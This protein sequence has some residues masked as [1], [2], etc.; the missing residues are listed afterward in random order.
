MSRST[1]DKELLKHRDKLIVEKY[2]KLYDIKRK[3]FDDVMY[4]LKWEYFFISEDTIK[5]ILRGANIDLPYWHQL[6]QS[7]KNGLELKQVRNNKAVTRF[8]ELCNKEKWR[9][10]DAINHLCREEFFISP[11]HFERI[12]T[13]WK[14][15]EKVTHNNLFDGINCARAP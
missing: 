6:N 7:H 3:R 2:V 5:R 13:K 12:V 1:S 11:I 9:L 10:D 4:S 15:I 14:I 8:D